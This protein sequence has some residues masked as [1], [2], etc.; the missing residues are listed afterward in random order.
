MSDAVN[1]FLDWVPSVRVA[2]KAGSEG[3]VIVLK[4]RFK[5][6]WLRR[7]SLRL[8]RPDTLSI[9]LDEA[10]SRVWRLI[11]GRRTVEAMAKQLPDVEGETSE[12]KLSR[13]VTF[14]TQLRQ[15][16]LIELK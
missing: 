10:G 8:G 13:L 2:S 3:H 14:L 9:H 7:L 16:G 12:V 11:D 6:F 5:A 1:N 15:N 4:P